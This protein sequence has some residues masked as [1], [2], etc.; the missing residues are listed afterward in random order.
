MPQRHARLVTSREQRRALGRYLKQRRLMLGLTQAE[1]ARRASLSPV[2]VLRYEAGT[3]GH[4]PYGSTLRRLAAVL[5]LPLA[6]LLTQAF[7][8]ESAPA[9]GD[10]GTPS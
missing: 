5:D 6:D 2:L 3:T 1:V 10:Q 7:A 9:P 8:P 4:S